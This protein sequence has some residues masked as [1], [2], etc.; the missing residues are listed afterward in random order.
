MYSKFSLLI[1]K[2]NFLMKKAKLILSGVLALGLVGGVFAFKANR[3]FKF[4]YT[5][6]KAGLPATVTVTGRNLTITGTAFTY[7]TTI[8]G[9][10]APATYTITAE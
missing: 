7:A 10:T 3:T 4:V 9:A 1:Y 8:F 2:D 5:T 6:T